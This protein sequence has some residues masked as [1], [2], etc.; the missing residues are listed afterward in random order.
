MATMRTH[1]RV[2][3][4]GQQQEMTGSQ[5][6]L[7]IQEGQWHAPT[8]G[9]APGYVQANLAIV[10]RTLAEDFERFCQLNPQPLP[11]LE[12]LPNGSPHTVSCAED[13]D[14]RTDVPKYW[15]YEGGVMKREVQNLL[16]LWQDDWCTFLLGCSFTF[17][18]LLVEA[19]IPVRH[20]EQHS[21]VSMYETTLPLQPSGAFQGKLVVS[22]R[23]IPADD[24]A[25]AV[26]LTKPLSLAHG[27][28]V[29][30][31]DPDALGIRDLAQPDY[32]DPVEINDGDIPVFWA[33]GVTTQAVARRC[34]IPFMITHAPGH[35][36][37]TDLTITS[38]CVDSRE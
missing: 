18:A 7:L 34:K 19:G 22:M 4:S 32:G 9:L 12:R 28:P 6:R 23:P 29:H 21:N 26:Q 37:I 38:C 5:A 25:R 2:D 16:D 33:C 30:M 11:L 3:L 15:I 14:L 24:L 31:G 1:R 27:E 8:A 36:L 20:L 17:D 35:L 13:A 10:E